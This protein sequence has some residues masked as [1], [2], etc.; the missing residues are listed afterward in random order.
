MTN[1]AKVRTRTRLVPP[2]RC[3]TRLLPPA[4]LPG[5]CEPGFTPG[6]SQQST[7]AAVF[8]TRTASAQQSGFTIPP[9]LATVSTGEA[10]PQRGPAGHRNKYRRR[11]ERAHQNAGDMLGRIE[12]AAASGDWRLN[13]RLVFKFIRNDYAKLAALAG[14][15]PAGVTS[16]TIST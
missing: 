5:T 4:A 3:R 16:P 11:M 14:S 9:V 2:L 6:A 13:R 10:A 8:A 12:E 1:V 7:I 15:N